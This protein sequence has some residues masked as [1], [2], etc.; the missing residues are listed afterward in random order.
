M[1][2]AEEEDS[3]KLRI[4]PDLGNLA[5]TALR[6][7]GAQSQPLVRVSNLPPATV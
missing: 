5:G 1:C 6:L 7:L 4:V 3:K 2:R